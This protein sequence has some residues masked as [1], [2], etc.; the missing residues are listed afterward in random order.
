[1]NRKEISEI[2]KQ[3]TIKNCSV[4][5]LCGCYVDGEK[6][7]RSKWNRSFLSLPEDEII[8]Y[9][10]ILRKVLC[11]GLGKDLV[12]V[13]MA[14]RNIFL[15]NLPLQA[16]Y[17]DK[18]ESALDAL[19][20]QT[21][22]SLEYEGPFAVLA[23]FGAYDVPGKTSDGIELEDGSEEVYAYTII[24]TCP[25]NLQKPGL[26]YDPEEGAFAPLRTARMLGAPMA[27][28]LYPAF[29]DRSQDPDYALCY[30]RNMDS[31]CRKL[32]EAL[33]GSRLP[34]PGKEER[35]AYMGTLERVLGRHA[36]LEEIRRI[37]ENLQKLKLEH[38]EDPEPYGMT[39]ADITLILRESGIDEARIG[40][41]PEA[42]GAEAGKGV[43]LTLDN[44]GNLKDFTITMEGGELSLDP[45]YAYRARIRELAGQKVLVLPLEGNVEANGFR[46][47]IGEVERG[48]RE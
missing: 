6:N 10:D 9:L 31:G 2:K 12:N 21:A 33:T 48:V 28:I 26:A 22:G 35:A 3:L 39:L 1:M 15:E 43:R 46:I 16:V 36:S 8:R 34:M 30:C 45:A 37:E 47:D 32:G 11:G 7:V 40:R 19:Y 17:L 24:C 18:N 5:R 13:K 23:A 29:N 4:S 14:A 42:Y 41:L 25:V 20:E 38:S 44:L 27:G